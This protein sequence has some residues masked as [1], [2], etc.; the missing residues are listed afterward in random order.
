MISIG[1]LLVLL[2]GL[3][4]LSAGGTIFT[5]GV[6]LGGVSFTSGDIPGVPLYPGAEQSTDSSG[7]SIP[8]DM[9]RVIGSDEAQ[10][11]RYIT[12]DSPDEVRAWYLEALADAGF[13]EPSH[14]ESGADVY[15]EGDVRYGVYVIELDGRTNIILAVGNE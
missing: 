6:P 8:Y 14:R 3:I 5:G 4:I 9:H 15:P 2:V 13:G 10:W 11:K 1:V 12:V 7:V